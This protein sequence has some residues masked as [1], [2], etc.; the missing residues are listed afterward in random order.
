MVLYATVLI[1]ISP[2]PST[3]AG[4]SAVSG[5]APTARQVG[6]DSPRDAALA[7]IVLDAASQEPVPGATITVGSTQVVAGPNGRFT[8]TAVG[9]EVALTVA[10]PGYFTLNTTVAIVS[11]GGSTVELLMVRESSVVDDVL[12]Q[13]PFVDGPPAARR[14]EPTEVLQTAGAL[15]NIFRALQVLPGVAASQEIS[16]FL[17]VRGGSPDQ[18]L[19]LL[20][21]VEVHDPYRLYG[22]AS[23][24]NPE[25]IQRFDLATGGFSAKYGDRLSSLLSVES[26]DGV[27]TERLRGSA[28]MSV[29]D[30]NV[31][32]EGAVPGVENASWLLNTRRTYYD[33]IANL[34]SDQDFPGFEDVQAKVVWRPR[35]GRKLT[36][37][38]LG[39]RQGG[40]LRI[41]E[42]DI[43]VHFRDDTKNTLGWARYESTVGSRGHTMTV[44][45]I[46]DTRIST[47][48]DG[49][50]ADKGR[51]SNAPDPL[52]VR[53]ANVGFGFDILR[54]RDISL[55]Q[56]AGW[57][58]HGHTLNIGFE[59]HDLTTTFGWSMRGDRN[60]NVSGS[61]I[62]G[63]AGLPETLGSSTRST[64]GA[65]WLEDSWTLGTA[66]SVQGGM[67]LDRV[68]ATDEWLL[69]P[70]VS[71]SWRLGDA[72]RLR[73]AVGRYTQS[74]GYEKLGQSDYLLD[75]TDPRG[76]GLRSQEAILASAGLERDLGA[77]ALVRVEGYYKRF[78][79][80]LVGQ[81]E[82][83]PVRLARVAQYNFPAAL[84]SNVPTDA[85]ITS[86]PSNDARGRS[87][88]VDVLVQRR[89]VSADTRL[90]GWASYTW[91]KAEREAYG[92]LYPFEYD[93][94]HAV[95]VVA[96][97]QL[98]PRWEI[99]TT[100]RLASGFPRTPPLG[101]RVAGVA[102]A[103][104]V[105]GNSVRTE[106]VPERDADGRLV[107]VVDF[108]GVRNLQQGSLPLFA[109][110][111][112]RVT[113]RPSSARWELYSEVLN[114]L[115]RKNAGALTPVLEHDPSSDRPRLVEE[116]AQSLPLLPTVG[117]RFKF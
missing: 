15:D 25:A 1:A 110:V 10:A 30:A 49:L 80:L 98:S 11:A 56:E 99:A 64:R 89:S 96:A 81:L 104:D 23:A 3:A 35:A 65:A 111:D 38:G 102:D 17:T 115:N 51:R 106:L 58:A 61:S 93:R 107:Y 78:D 18:N 62:Q 6:V 113:W 16:G 75:L 36:L 9:G 103:S 82:T 76:Q 67:R 7:G 94:R 4:Q 72:T 63:G 34:V 2:F 8:L 27:S 5:D 55:R 85:I 40:D 66:F 108:G 24:F 53:Q 13:A 52:P 91:G 95:T 43:N 42:D 28:S 46:S 45:G 71:T 116:R 84:A 59:A 54:L 74:P 26:R 100:T 14:V 92:L 105:N 32:L 22:L 44:A 41:D 19:T 117:I 79:D 73:S 29:T 12:V 112:A 114:V 97:Y 77:S 33:V 70:R 21:G 60:P 37:F 87:Y 90:R 57:A 69:S 48:F 39:S 86:T 83:E 20:D 31:V 101:L 68:E 47:S 88:G 50:F 109:R